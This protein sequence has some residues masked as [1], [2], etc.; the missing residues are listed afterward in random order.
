MDRQAVLTWMAEQDRTLGYLANRAG[1]DAH[2]LAQALAGVMAPEGAMLAA[3]ETAM[4]L[5]EGE[6]SRD[7]E[8][9][10]DNGTD[11]LRCF[12]VDEVAARMQVHP[13]TVRKEI[14]EGALQ[15]IVVGDRAIRVPHNALEERFSQW[16]G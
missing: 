13:D 1:V 5:A 16:R 9:S 7:V 8:H 12:T 2:A 15:H 11:G 6:L 10:P 14:R 4:N 3:L